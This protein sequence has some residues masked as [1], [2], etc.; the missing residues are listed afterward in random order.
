MIIVLASCKMS[1]SSALYCTTN[2]LSGPLIVSFRSGKFEGE[3]GVL[4]H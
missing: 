3:V 2:S 1:K 4:L